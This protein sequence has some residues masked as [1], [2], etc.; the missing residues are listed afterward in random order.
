[1][2]ITAT[3]DRFEGDIAVLVVEPEQTKANVPRS[4]LPQDAAQGDVV[5]LEGTVDR[6]ETEK[7]RSEIQEQIER[8]KQR[9]G[10]G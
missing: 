4:D 2:P 6:E 3:I 1:M 7:R 9:S 10:Q 8:L 5:R